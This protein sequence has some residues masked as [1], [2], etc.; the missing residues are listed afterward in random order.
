MGELELVEWVTPL[1]CAR[2][3]WYHVQHWLALAHR[4]ILSGHLFF[5]PS[6]F[7]S[8]FPE[9]LLFNPK[10]EKEVWRVEVGRGFVGP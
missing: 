7:L 10:G 4:S 5:F 6:F 8:F 1:S 3:F 2:S 9:G